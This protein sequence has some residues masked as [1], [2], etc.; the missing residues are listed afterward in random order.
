MG[1]GVGRRTINRDARQAGVAE[2]A[3]LLGHDYRRTR[4]DEYHAFDAFVDTWARRLVAKRDLE[5]GKLA[6]LV[7]DGR[8]VHLVCTCGVQM[9]HG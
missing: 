8:G 5:L 6:R 2:D 7:R 1:G 3:R 4:G 9:C